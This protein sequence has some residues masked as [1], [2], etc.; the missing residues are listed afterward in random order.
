MERDY[1]IRLIADA[2]PDV[3]ATFRLTMD[4]ANCNLTCTFDD[5]TLFATESDFFA[6]LCTIRRK[7]EGMG[8]RP[9]C[10]GASLNA[11]P[12]AMSRDMGNGLSLYR[13]EIG[14]PGERAQ[15]ARTFETGEDVVPSTVD[16]QREYHSRW[17]DSL[18]QRN[19]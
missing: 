8:R 2:A 4:G 17:F 19:A 15:I 11:Y 3:N 1:T 13:T 12:S 14:K 6:A 16:E 18:G 9:H 7:L 5:Q 10:Y